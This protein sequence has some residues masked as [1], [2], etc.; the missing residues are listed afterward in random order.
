MSAST[1]SVAPSDLRQELPRVRA[2]LQRAGLGGLVASLA[3]GPYGLTILHLQALET[4][5]EACSAVLELAAR[6]PSRLPEDG[7]HPERREHL[8]LLFGLFAAGMAGAERCASLSPDAVALRAGFPSSRIE[9]LLT[10]DRDE[11]AW[12]LADD[13][14]EFLARHRDHPDPARRLREPRQV[15]NS[16]GAWLGLVAR[17]AREVASDGLYEP[18]RG[19]LEALRIEV[20]GWVFRGFEGSPAPPAEEPAELLPL[21]PEDIVGNQ[22]Y[23]AAGMRLARDVAGFDLER[24]ENPKRLNPVL[25]A[26]GRPGCGKTVT[27]HAIGN[28]FLGYCR[29]RGVPARFRVIRRTDWASSYQN[30]SAQKLVDLFRQEV[31]A[32]PGVV[33]VY[34]PDID[35]A[36]AARTDPGLRSEERNILGA[37][38]GVF[39][40][41]LIPKNGKWFLLCDA[42]FTTMDEATLSRITQ[43]PYRLAGPT[44]AGDFVNL[45]RDKLLREWA[46]L[47]PLSEE[48]W[49]AVGRRCL[50]LDLS[51]RN[52]EALCRKIATEIEDVEPPDEYYRVGF[53]ERRRILRELSRPVPA[54]RV[55]ELMEAYA[56]FEREAEASARQQRFAERVREIVLHLS[57]ERAARELSN[58]PA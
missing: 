43:D 8:A 3:P 27:A 40:G 38:F 29:E 24:G 34:W 12:R 48:E 25:F 46:G 17:G 52:V 26:L 30:A 36:F 20:S 6:L 45:M 50:E 58:P 53:E 23:L 10:L 5:E 42:N 32:F 44:T 54:P 55:L 18:F 31:Q 41:T 39:D 37:S 9:A 22:D 57:A 28:Y 1:L 21:G 35:T 14:H 4:V 11:L 7:L 13:L 33:G 49:L 15:V 56:R 19:A 51:G 2:Q 16:V 47:L